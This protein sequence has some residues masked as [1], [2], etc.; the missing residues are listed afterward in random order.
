MAYLRTTGLPALTVVAMLALAG[1]AFADYATAPAGTLYTGKISAKHAGTHVSLHGANGILI[2]CN[3]AFE[4]EITGHGAWKPV[5][6]P[7]TSLEFTKCTGTSTVHV[8][9][10]GTFEVEDTGIN[11]NGSVYS[12]GAEIEVTTSTIFGAVSCVYTTAN[13]FI[14]EITGP[15]ASEPENATLDLEASLPRTGGS[16]LCG[17]KGTWTG[18]YTITSPANL[19]IDNS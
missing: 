4:G 5:S 15:N 7:V 6:G 13:T 9:K 12:K 8:K 11:G 14:G 1:V 17:D 16:S 18:K 10:T 19:Y 2:E 3:S